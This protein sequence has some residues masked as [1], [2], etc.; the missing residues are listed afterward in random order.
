[1]LKDIIRI[2]KAKNIRLYNG[3]FQYSNCEVSFTKFT[4][5]VNTIKFFYGIEDAVSIA[6][7]ELFP[8]DAND[9]K[10]KDGNRNE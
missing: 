3:V 5:Y 7:K 2:S 10:S 1:M 8:V 6:K 4:G 9:S